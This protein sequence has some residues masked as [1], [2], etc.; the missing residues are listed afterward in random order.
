MKNYTK[1]RD[2]FNLVAVDTNSKLIKVVRIGADRKAD[3]RHIG[4]MVID[5]EQ[6]KLIYTD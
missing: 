3:M 1:T 5:Y 4:T 2:L 6:R